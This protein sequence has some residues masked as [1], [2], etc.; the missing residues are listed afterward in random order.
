MK[1][2]RKRKASPGTAS[3]LDYF[4]N[5]NKENSNE[6][7]RR[8]VEKKKPDDDS[9][10]K[11]KPRRILDSDSEVEEL[12]QD[13]VMRETA[14]PV[15]RERHQRPKYVEES[16]EEEESSFSDEEGE[17]RMQMGADDDSI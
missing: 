9:Q 12:K 3:M 17:A 10:Q 15:I 16:S 14:K 2:S 7:Q 4:K 5:N 11:V 1:G 13:T 8:K 6:L